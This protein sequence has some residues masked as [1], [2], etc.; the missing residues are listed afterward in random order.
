MQALKLIPVA[1]AE[2]YVKDKVQEQ[3][4][5]QRLVRLPGK[6]PE[7]LKRILKYSLIGLVLL[8][9]GAGGF[10]WWR[11]A[12]MW[13]ETD[14][15]TIVGHV[16][17]LSSRVEGVVAEVLVDDNQQ[18]ERGA[19]I[20]RLDPRDYETKVMSAVAT[21]NR[22]LGQLEVASNTVQAS[23]ASAD[24]AKTGASSE[25][26]DAE[27]DIARAEAAVADARA[28]VSV[29]EAR[30]TQQKAEVLRAN[31]DYQRYK[32]LEKEGAISTQQLDNARRDM[33]VADAAL[34]ASQDQYAQAKARVRQAMDSVQVAKAKLLKS[35]SSAQ[36]AESEQHQTTVHQK[37]V[38]VARA[39]VQ[40]AQAELTA[41]ELNL[42]YATIK[43]PVNGTVGRKTVEVG[44]RIQ[45]GQPLMALISP[46]RWVVANFKET[47]LGRMKPG[48]KAE[49]TVDALP[50]QTL[51]GYVDS[52]SPASGAQ[53]ALLP[54]D[55][56]TGNFTKIVQRVPVKIRLSDES[57]NKLRDK[58]TP[59][60]SVIA[61]IKVGE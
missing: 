42:S 47:Q 59:G 4:E 56:A 32:A 21:K 29:A 16:H 13:E 41:A 60:M 27:A 53:F 1:Q 17:M 28:G 30:I 57:V 31:T 45:P 46:D 7:G 6:S 40:E 10:V 44:Q 19:P 15:A 22:A 61:K 58:L 49:I 34:R 8:A 20:V 39:N 23:V 54:P 43:A 18:V 36:Q 11:H 52:F 55:N 14:N 38:G 2:Q 3:I 12:A 37:E 26:K 25:Y 50:G 51:E 48:Q 9:L 5:R 35:T 24:A 33:E